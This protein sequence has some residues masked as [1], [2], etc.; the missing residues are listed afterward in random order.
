MPFTGDRLKAAREHKGFTQRELGALTGLNETQISRYEHGKWA[1][2]LKYLEQI[3]KHLEVTADFLI[4]LT[5]D[6]QKR[7][8]DTELAIDERLILETFRAESWPGIIRLGADRI[9]R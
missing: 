1:P 8:T 9:A 4:G 6:P 5:D 2:S 3:A 7:F